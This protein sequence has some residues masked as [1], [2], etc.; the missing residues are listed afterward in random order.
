MQ[1][2][3]HCNRVVILNWELPQFWLFLAAFGTPLTRSFPI[4]K[5]H[6]TF[7]YITVNILRYII[8]EIVFPE[9]FNKKLSLFVDLY[10]SP[11]KLGRKIYLCGR[12]YVLYTGAWQFHTP[13]GS[14]N[15]AHGD[16][17]SIQ[18][19]VINFV[20]DLLQ[21]G[22]FLRVFQFP[23]PIKLTPWYNWNIVESGIKHH[24]SYPLT[25][26]LVAT[27]WLYCL[28]P[29]FWNTLAKPKSA[30]FKCPVEL[31]NKLAGFK[32][33]NVSKN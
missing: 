11:N 17:Y 24:N 10:L 28:F 18:R 2:N 19:C 22:G 21:V 1:Y 4:K 7:I 8:W 23:P 3:Y 14:W 6:K 26:Y 30:I 9:Y 13:G 12:F 16:L 31:I 32:S 20:S 29:T 27:W 25:L 33:W 15:P 5:K